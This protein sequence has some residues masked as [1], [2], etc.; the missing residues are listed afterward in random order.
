LAA[1]RGISKQ[2]VV[3]NALRAMVTADEM[4]SEKDGAG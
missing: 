4:E 1:R 2:A 3:E